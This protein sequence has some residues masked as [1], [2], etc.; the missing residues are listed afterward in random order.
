MAIALIAAVMLAAALATFLLT[1]R[2]YKVRMERFSRVEYRRGFGAGQQQPATEA[3]QVAAELQQQIRQL[4]LDLAL[5]TP[6]RLLAKE[7]D[8]S[9][10]E[11][12]RIKSALRQKRVL[13][14]KIQGEVR[15]LENDC[16][17]YPGTAKLDHKQGSIDVKKTQVLQLQEQIKI[18]EQALTA[19]N[20]K[21]RT[22]VD[23]ISTKQRELENTN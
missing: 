8:E 2:I 15:K 1:R 7:R 12:D 14:D 6:L 16:V 20:N 19:E 5:L 10:A 4:R 11:I 23:N 18:L 9:L 22:I 21:L 13:V 3:Q 17:Q